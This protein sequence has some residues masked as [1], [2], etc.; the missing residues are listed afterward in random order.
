MLLILCTML[1]PKLCV[2]RMHEAAYYECSMCK[3]FLSS[4]HLAAI[5]FSVSHKETLS[6]PLAQ[7]Q[8]F[9]PAVKRGSLAV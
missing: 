6:V 7:R 2:R 9:P 4:A 3:V 8:R 1:E 5:H